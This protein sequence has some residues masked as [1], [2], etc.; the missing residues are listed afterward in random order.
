MKRLIVL[1]ISLLSIGAYAD[2]NCG[3]KYVTDSNAKWTG[4]CVNGQAHG[5]GLLSFTYNNKTHETFG[6]FIN[7][8]WTGLH[9]YTNGV[10]KF[11]KYYKNSVESIVGPAIVTG[12]DNI[13][14]P[15]YKRLWADG[16]AEPDAN[17]KQPVISY[18]K[19]LSDI[20][21]YIAQRN[22]PSVDFEIFKAYL[23]GRVRVTGVDDAPA[24]GGALKPKVG[25][26]STKKK[27]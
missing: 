18:E 19:A 11:V 23:E 12:N 26:K 1:C 10:Y 17:N 8:N 5:I 14:L 20:Q 21:A 16:N 6:K 25:G 9:L 2:S 27:K 15:L 13:N 7:G 3:A 4:E 22:E 24:S